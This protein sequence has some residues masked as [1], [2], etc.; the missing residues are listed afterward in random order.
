VCT[1]KGVIF[2]SWW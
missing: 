1:Q 2:I